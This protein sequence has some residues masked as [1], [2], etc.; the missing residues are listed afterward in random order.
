VT[1][2][3]LARRRV[4][5]FKSFLWLGVALWV[6]F[7]VAPLSDWARHWEYAQS[8]QFCVY[9][10]GVPA[11]LVLGSLRLGP[12]KDASFDADESNA[13]KRY[14][15]ARTRWVVRTILMILS[16]V[17]W[18]LSPVVDA[19]VHHSW[20]GV[21]EALFLTLVGILFWREL[22]APLAVAGAP[23][24]LFRLVIATLVMWTIW[25]M[26]YLAGLSGGSWYYSFHHHAGHGL[27]LTADQQIS[28][29]ILWLLSA[30]GFLPVI[31]LN[32]TRWLGS[33]K[34]ARDS[35]HHFTRSQ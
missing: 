16:V 11:L 2:A 13:K 25:I 4:F 9:A 6:L 5:S 34:D 19:L 35:R 20:L 8:L 17:V 33:E 24:P 21:I 18:R 1:D 14:A 23:D 29:A 30:C 28:A 26:A 10:F 15:S 22:L 3:T 7:L 31:F 32:L 12:A 27:S